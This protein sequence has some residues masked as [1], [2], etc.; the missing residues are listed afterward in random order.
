MLPIISLWSCKRDYNDAGYVGT[1]YISASENFA[2]TTPFSIQNSGSDINSTFETD[3]SIDD[4]S[5][6]AEFN[7]PV[8]WEIL[9]QGVK[10]HATCLLRGVSSSINSLNSKWNG[11]HDGIYFFESEDS[12]IVTLSVIGY[13]EKSIKSFKIAPNG[14]KNYKLAKP[15]MSFIYRTD[16]EQVSSILNPNTL[17]INFFPTQFSIS[18]S[19]VQTGSVLQSDNIKA[20]EGKRYGMVSGRSTAANGFFVGGIQHRV[21]TIGTYYINWTDPSQVYVNLYVNG[22]DNLLPNSKPAGVLNFEFHEDD[23]GDQIC[24]GSVD[25]NDMHCPVNEDSW[26]YKIPITHSGWKLFSSKYSSLQ[27]AEDAA[28]GGSGNRVLQPNR[29]YRVQMGLISNPP[30]NFVEAQFDFACFTLGAPFDPKTF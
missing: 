9:I 3:F 27:P 11:Y 22:V 5:F 25:A 4:I 29:I 16:F 2:I 7:E 28:N 24:N 15:N 26:V 14:Q 18:P 17:N 30:F 20:P 23:R 21:G 10:S 8:S 13:K 19:G 1:A 6:R 12:L